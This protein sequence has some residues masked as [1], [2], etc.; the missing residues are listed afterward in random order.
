MTR[1]QEDPLGNPG[2]SYRMIGIS[3]CVAWVAALAFLA[4][5][6]QAADRN[7]QDTVLEKLRPLQELGEA[8]EARY[9]LPVTLEEPLWRG[10]G[11]AQGDDGRR[12]PFFALRRMR[13]VIPGGLLPENPAGFHLIHLK[14]IL[15]LY[16]RDGLDPI[17]FDA[18]SSEWGLH[19]VPVAIRT[20]NGETV[21]V[22]SLLDLPVHVEQRPRMASEH[23]RVLCEAIQKS[24]GRVVPAAA[25]LDGWYAAGGLIPPKHAAAVLSEK[26]RERYTFPWGVERTSGRDALISLLRL[27]ATT[28]TWRLLCRNDMGMGKECYLQLLPMEVQDLDEQGR[29]VLDE[30][31]KPRLRYRLHD[32][33]NKVP[34]KAP[35]IRIQ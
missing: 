25:Y 16:N 14:E 17:Q 9:G 18:I 6:P 15:S 31:G 21:K 13:F 4:G 22:S 29:P 28:L 8:L 11:G 30:A 34:L 2:Q 7:Q 33:L 27:S 10:S 20:E 5:F 3:P 26:E 19:I 32:R 12:L 1:S 23:F 24:G 35:P